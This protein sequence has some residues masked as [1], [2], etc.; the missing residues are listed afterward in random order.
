[1]IPVPRVMNHS[2]GELDAPAMATGQDPP[3]VTPE[4][5]L[6]D[7]ELLDPEDGVVVGDCSALD[8]SDWLLEV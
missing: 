5:E 7:P 8:E 4:P 1:M 2:A 3:D 6:L